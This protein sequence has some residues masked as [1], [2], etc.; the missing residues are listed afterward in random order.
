MQQTDAVKPVE[1]HFTSILTE[2]F[3]LQENSG[4]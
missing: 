3:I 2:S 4:I 1:S